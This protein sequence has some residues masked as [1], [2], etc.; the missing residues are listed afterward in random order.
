MAHRG[1]SKK[2]RISSGYVLLGLVLLLTVGAYG[3]FVYDPNA[4]ATSTLN[5]ATTQRSNV[6]TWKNC[7]MLPKKEGATWYTLSYIAKPKDSF[8][9]H[10]CFAIRGNYI[11][12][13][14]DGHG[15]PFR[16]KAISGEIFDIHPN[17]PVWVPQEF[18]IERRVKM[19]AFRF[20]SMD[21]EATRITITVKKPL[22]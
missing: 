18:W 22:D 12:E 8:S 9:E 10:S 14:A 5:T 16:V 4:P 21:K 17:S 13:N 7:V 2:K 11:L 20:Y 19:L 6:I 15:K 3:L 1:E